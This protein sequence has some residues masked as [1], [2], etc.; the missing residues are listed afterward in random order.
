MSQLL[1]LLQGTSCTSQNKPDTTSFSIFSRWKKLKLRESNLL[2]FMYLLRG[3][4]RIW[5]LIC[6]RLKSKSK[7]FLLCYISSLR[8]LW[9][10]GFTLW[11]SL[12]I[13]RFF[14]CGPYHEIF[15]IN[16]TCLL[17]VHASVAC[18]QLLL[19]LSIALPN[20]LPLS[21]LS[22]SLFLCIPKC[23]GILLII[24]FF[25][26]RKPWF[27]FYGTIFLPTEKLQLCKT[28]SFQTHLSMKIF[29][30]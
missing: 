26:S 17:K 29:H 13:P 20:P 3:W 14:W 6:Q 22:S 24:L 28:P 9:H 19:H 10:L 2:K 27:N 7:L 21:F 4:A 1:D 25:F 5:L 12:K 15:F 23:F 8:K 30:F 16:L 18:I 11:F